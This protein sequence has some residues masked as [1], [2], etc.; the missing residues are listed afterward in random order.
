M[1]GSGYYCSMVRF[2]K[3]RDRKILALK[4]IENLK[5]GFN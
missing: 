4:E 2:Y 1:K 3:S 5:R